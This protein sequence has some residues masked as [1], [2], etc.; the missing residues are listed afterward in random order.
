MRKDHELLGLDQQ[1]PI[2]HFERPHI[3][4]KLNLKCYNRMMWDYNVVQMYR[5]IFT[6]LVICQISILFG[7]RSFLSGTIGWTSDLMSIRIYELVWSTICWY[8]KNKL[9]TTCTLFN[10][11]FDSSI[12][13]NKW[14][15]IKNVT[16]YLSKILCLIFI[17]LHRLHTDGAEMYYLLYLNPTESRTRKHRLSEKGENDD[18]SMV[19]MLNDNHKLTDWRN[20]GFGQDFQCRIPNEKI[21]LWKWSK[22]AF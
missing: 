8:T 6:D 4:I 14:V 7:A 3:S 17:R 11:K 2:L 16:S 19:H 15:P 12:L 22:H 5:Q 21:Q 9:I 1:P 20:P 10:V 13:Q 18:L